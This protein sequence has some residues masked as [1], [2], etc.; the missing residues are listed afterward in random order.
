MRI[1]LTEDPPVLIRAWTPGAMKLL[2]F[3]Q[4][5]ILTS[6]GMRILYFVLILLA[7][8]ACRCASGGFFRALDAALKIKIRIL[9]SAICLIAGF[10]ILN[11]GSRKN[12]F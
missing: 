12:L 6:Y 5:V 10:I 9:S 7:S 8:M 4:N 11:H 3:L 1:D 2:H